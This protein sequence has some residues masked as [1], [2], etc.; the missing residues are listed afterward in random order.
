MSVGNN[1]IE[2]IRTTV[3]PKKFEIFSKM[4]FSKKSCDKKTYK[5]TPK[6]VAKEKK[7]IAIDLKIMALNLCF[8]RS[9]MDFFIKL[10]NLSPVIF[11]HKNVGN[12]PKY[13]IIGKN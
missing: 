10:Y 12:Y 3:E 9:E 11:L 13:I 1:I 6:R 4:A 2:R 8:F 5:K 7:L